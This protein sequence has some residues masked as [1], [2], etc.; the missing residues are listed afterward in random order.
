M[1]PVLFRI[2]LPAYSLKYGWI[3]L[4]AAVIALLFAVYLGLAR[5][6]KRGSLVA[7]ATSVAF[8]GAYFARTFLLHAVFRVENDAWKMAPI[9][10]YSY[11]VMLGLSLVVG[12]YVSLGLAEREGLPKETMGNTYVLTALAALVGA[13]LLYVVTNLSQFDS[14]ASVADLRG[15]GMVA[16]GGFLGGLLGSYAYLR[17]KKIPLL[18]WA[19]AAVPSL[20]AGVMITRIGCYLLGCDFGTVLDNKAP[21]FLKTLGTFPKWTQGDLVGSPAWA[22]HVRDGLIGVDAAYSKPVH[23]T[24]LYESLVGGALLLLLL[25]ARRHQ[26]FRGELFFIFAF[27]YG[28]CRYLLEIVRDDIERGSV[29]FS[30]PRHILIPFGLV[31]F[32]VGYGI[33]FSQAIENVLVRR[34]TQ[35][36]AFAPVAV[37]YGILK[38]ES[39]TS[40]VDAQYS[41]SQ[42]IALLTGF[43]VSM[44]FV[45]LYKAALAHPAQAMALGFPALLPAA[46]DPGAAAAVEPTRGTTRTGRRE[47]KRSDKGASAEAKPRKTNRLKAASLPSESSPAGSHG[48][49]ADGAPSDE[50]AE[51]ANREDGDTKDRAEHGRG[52]E[53]EDGQGTP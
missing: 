26:K 17:A 25:W 49:P 6:D 36:L 8:L 47:E 34:I 27:V 2:P 44:A 43:A 1:H 45:V 39:F 4:A 13:R 46:G 16:Y 40:A 33:G 24:Q 50:K 37:T 11:G 10:I 53:P 15:G 20:A 9:P 52:S 29:P 12:W 22:Q 30:L 19:D 31:L 42:A 3:A 7:L 48:A 14:L 41:T 32:A 18:P 51:G 28:L 35:V 38:P 5:R 23:P 21:A